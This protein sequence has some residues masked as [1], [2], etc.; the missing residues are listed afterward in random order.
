M[1]KYVSFIMIIFLLFNVCSISVMGLDDTQVVENVTED[2][3]HELLYYD[4]VIYPDIK[5]EVRAIT[6]TSPDPFYCSTKGT[7]YLVYN[8]PGFSKPI[9]ELRRIVYLDREV[10]LDLKKIYDS[11]KA[12][13]VVEYIL[14]QLDGTITS[15]IAAGI[16]KIIGAGTSVATLIGVAIPTAVFLIKNLE[17]WNFNSALQES[18][19]GK[20]KVYSGLHNA[21][22]LYVNF[23]SYDTWDDGMVTVPDGYNYSWTEG[24]CDLEGIVDYCDHQFGNWAVED[25]SKHVKKCTKCSWEE[26]DNHSLIVASGPVGELYH[27]MECVD[28]NYTVTHSHTMRWVS[29]GADTHKGTCTLCNYTKTESHTASYDNVRGLCK[30]CGYTGP[31]SSIMSILLTQR[32]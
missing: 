26:F 31:I 13:E 24:F 21:E 4:D 29:M 19:T 16:A 5:N 17:R 7:L 10:V 11:Q 9:T 30:K 22:G 12:D 14:G 15:A 20:L 23:V 18:T 25:S 3:S 6:A 2:D 8:G 32:E 1:K 27:T 28:C